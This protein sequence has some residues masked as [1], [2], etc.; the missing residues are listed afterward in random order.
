MD[1]ALAAIL[2]PGTDRELTDKTWL[3][4]AAFRQTLFK[5]LFILDEVARREHDVLSRPMGGLTGDRATE[6]DWLNAVHAQSEVGFYTEAFFIYFRV[7]A[8][9]FAEAF[10]YAVQERHKPWENYRALLKKASDPS[11][12]PSLRFADGGARVF[13]VVRSH[14]AWFH[15]LTH[16]S[17]GHRGIRDAIL[18][19]PLQIQLSASLDES[20]RTTGVF[21]H[22]ISLAPDAPQIDLFATIFEIVTGFCS[23][24]SALP[25]E[26][27]DGRDHFIER[28]LVLDYVGDRPAALR[29]FPVIAD[30]SGG[31]S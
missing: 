30:L 16:P 13:E 12:W 24:L 5:I 3:R 4:V 21:L 2:V 8:D 15:L 11:S 19:Q 22:A 31:S 9:R 18:H 25:I 29:F 10:A 27:W 7:L 28:D 20:G 23:L 1:V 26:V 17:G 14:S 6:E